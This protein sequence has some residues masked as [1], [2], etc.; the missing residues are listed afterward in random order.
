MRFVK[1][2]T[3]VAIAALCMC[4]E[5]SAQIYFDCD[6]AFSRNLFLDQPLEAS[7]GRAQK[8]YFGNKDHCYRFEFKCDGGLFGGVF[9]GVD[10]CNPSSAAGVDFFPGIHTTEN[11]W[12]PGD[13]FCDGVFSTVGNNQSSHT[14]SFDHGNARLKIKRAD[15]EMCSDDLQCP[16]F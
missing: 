16:P 4:Q 12:Q 6:P 9:A 5:A 3:L 10:P 13:L 14:C 7:E 2:D 15:G 11:F 1:F 8:A